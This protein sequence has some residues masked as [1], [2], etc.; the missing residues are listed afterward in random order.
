MPP[1]SESD[2]YLISFPFFPFEA[3]THTTI[4]LQADLTIK[5]STRLYSA[6]LVLTTLDSSWFYLPISRLR[7]KLLS[8]PIAILFTKVSENNFRTSKLA[9]ISCAI[10]YCNC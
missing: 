1:L 6:R 7:H 8:Q 5:L 3:A 2:L 4:L 9:H 10:I